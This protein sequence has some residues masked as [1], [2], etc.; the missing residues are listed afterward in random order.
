MVVEAVEVQEALRKIEI[1]TFL[2]CAI[3]DHVFDG[4]RQCRSTRHSNWRLHKRG[5]G[6]GEGPQT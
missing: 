4:W 5:F 2:F 6:S 3:E 1:R